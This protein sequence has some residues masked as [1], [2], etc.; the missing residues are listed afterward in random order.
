MRF[1]VLS[2]VVSLLC[3]CSNDIEDVRRQANDKE[4]P[5][6]STKNVTMLYS[7]SA[8]LRSKV[9]APLRETYMGENE[10]VEFP[11]G[12]RIDFFEGNGR[13]NG[14]L[15]ADYALS[16]PRTETMTA[17]HNVV[18]SNGEGKTLTTEELIWEQKNG[19]IHSNKFSTIK[20]REEIIYGDGFEANQDFSE[21]RIVKVK[22]I[23]T[24]KE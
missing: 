7:D 11:K 6:S 10:R 1:V 3:A 18:L 2:F 12:I 22:G 24:L 4:M 23:V 16:N 19:R 21:Y 17:R 15:S 20:S 9:R 8:R 13:P 14:S 5:V